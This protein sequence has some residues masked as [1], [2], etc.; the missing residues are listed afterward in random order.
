MCYLVYICTHFYWVYTHLG[1]NL[2]QI[3]CGCSA[4]A[5]HAREFSKVVISI[6][7]PIIALDPYQHLLLSLL[8]FSH[9]GKCVMVSHYDL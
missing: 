7:T 8:N 3:L 9:S 2:G 4:L 1:M 6:R 5:E